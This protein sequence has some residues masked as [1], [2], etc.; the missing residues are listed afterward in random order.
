MAGGRGRRRPNSNDSSNLNWS[1]GR[2]RAS[3]S[4][5]SKSKFRGGKNPSSSN[6]SATKSVAKAASGSKSDSR[7]SNVT[8]IGF[9]YPSVEFQEGFYSELRKGSDADKDMD[10]S[11]PLV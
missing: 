9:Q 1:S 2:R 3:S 10:E 5:S 6:K 4:S 11:C 8:A 7:R